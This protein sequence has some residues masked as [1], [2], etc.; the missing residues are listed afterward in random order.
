MEPSEPFLAPLLCEVKGGELPVAL[1]FHPM[2]LFL[3]DK[4]A[5]LQS[6][7]TTPSFG[8]DHVWHMRPKRQSS[9]GAISAWAE[10]FVCTEHI[11]YLSYFIGT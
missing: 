6:L 3:Y 7:A 2:E 1:S 10:Y 11:P 5:P 9:D 8:V 4:R